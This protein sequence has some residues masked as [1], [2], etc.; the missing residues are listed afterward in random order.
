M[1]GAGLIWGPG[2]MLRRAHQGD[3]TELHALRTRGS[4]LIPGD[5][6]MAPNLL[7]YPG[8]LHIAVHIGLLSRLIG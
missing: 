1:R 5:A 8:L 3:G 4:G 2:F 6:M 7:R